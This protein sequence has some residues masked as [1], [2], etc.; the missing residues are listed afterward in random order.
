M[1]L[2]KDLKVWRQAMDLA[3]FV[4]EITASFP[5]NLI[6]VHRSLITHRR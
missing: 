2:H 3:K 4:Y 5:L 6:T 1:A